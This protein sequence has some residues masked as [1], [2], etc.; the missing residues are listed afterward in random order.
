MLFDMLCPV[1]EQSPLYARGPNSDEWSRI[2]CSECLINEPSVIFP[3]RVEYRPHDDPQFK[4]P[5]DYWRL[6]EAI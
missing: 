1:C 6:Q 5:E 3:T 4:T 2:P